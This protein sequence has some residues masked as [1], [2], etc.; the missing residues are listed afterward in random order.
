MVALLP[1]QNV[2]QFRFGG[3]YQN[4]PF[5]NV[6]HWEYTGAAPSGTAL[7]ELC[8]DALGV[9]DTALS[10]ILT[11]SVTL[12]TVRGLDLSAPDAPQSASD[13]QAAVGD[14]V[15]TAPPVNVAMCVSWLVNYRWRGGHFRTYF[16]AG[17]VQSIQGGNSWTSTALTNGRLAVTT[18]LTNM[19]AMTA[20]STSG[21][22]VG[23]KRWRTEVRGQPP[24]EINPPLVLPF[25][26]AIVDSRIDSQRRRLGRDVSA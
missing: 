1:V 23:V 3:S 16:P 7:K 10:A 5:L 12:N 20:G 4:Q 17:A 8:N 24:V 26:G 6:L 11:T 21:H 19:N 14:L 15:G 13:V 2:I 9:W 22:L 25:V 18:F